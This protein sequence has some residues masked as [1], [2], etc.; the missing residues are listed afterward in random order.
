MRKPIERVPVAEHNYGLGGWTGPG[1]DRAER[2]ER[3]GT[4]PPRTFLA[5]GMGDTA[6]SG[7]FYR[8]HR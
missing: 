4:E 1:C 3:E 8:T 2:R 5:S 6:R 7:S